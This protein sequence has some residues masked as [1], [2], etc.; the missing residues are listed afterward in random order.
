MLVFG[1]RKNEQIVIDDDIVVT[2]VAIRGE[3]VRLGVEAPKGVAVHRREVYE[4]I[5]G[6]L[7]AAEVLP[8]DQGRRRS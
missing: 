8:V 3:Q 4:A 7:T 2:V 6:A 5:H 1:R